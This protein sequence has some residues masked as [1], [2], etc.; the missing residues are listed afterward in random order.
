MATKIRLSKLQTELLKAM[1]AG[2]TLS[3]S[4]GYNHGWRLGVPGES[5]PKHPLTN[6][7]NACLDRGLI[8]GSGGNYVISP[9]ALA[10]L[11]LT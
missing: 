8:V 9:E 1:A 7:V 11:D 6:T 5:Y 2:A 10:A 4:W 3:Y